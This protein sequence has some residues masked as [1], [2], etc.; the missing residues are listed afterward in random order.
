VW[1]HLKEAV[2]D[3]EPKVAAEPPRKERQALADAFFALP[4]AARRSL[5]SRARAWNLNLTGLAQ[6]L[7]VGA[8]V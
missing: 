2:D 7:Q 4:A 6:N 8:A 5:G 3:E 1:W